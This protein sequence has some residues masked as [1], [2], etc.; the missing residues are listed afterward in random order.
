MT[1]EEHYRRLVKMYSR[2]TIND[3]YDPT[4]SVK[5]G[6]AEI[7]MPVKDIFFHSAGAIHGSVYFK[8]LDDAAC[9][10]A[11][12]REKEFFIVTSCLT[13]YITRP[14]WEGNLR[15]VGRI[16]NQSKNQFIVE[17][18]AYDD[19]DRVV[20][21]ANGIVMKGRDKLETLEHYIQ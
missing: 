1:S 17:S 2:A 18:T 6:E 9:F 21:K 20:A 12:S 14:V 15:A 13:T 5:D 16:A 10:A 11:W 19:E 8:I 7:I 4:I 3:L